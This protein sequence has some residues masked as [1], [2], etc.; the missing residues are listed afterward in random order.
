MDSAFGLALSKRN[1]S[2]KP[3]AEFH[4]RRRRIKDA[5]EQ[6]L[7]DPPAKAHDAIDDDDGNPVAMRCHEFRIGVDVNNFQCEK[8]RFL[9]A[10]YHFQGII[11]QA[12][13]GS[14]VE[15]T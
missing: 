5:R 10:N 2:A 7:V 8:I 3:Q 4:S 13:P 6:N 9:Q 14:C 12:A 11:A 1:L 15:Y